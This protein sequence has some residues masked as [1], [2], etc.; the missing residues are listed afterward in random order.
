MT[1]Q[2]YMWT[3]VVVVVAHE[4]APGHT[5][6]LLLVVLLYMSRYLS[7]SRSDGNIDTTAHNN[8]QQSSKQTCHYCCNMQQ[9]PR[10]QPVFDYYT[11]LQAILARLLRALLAALV[12]M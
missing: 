1:D 4:N 10:L 7:R 9:L 3:A 11:S 12:I 6:E 8:K 2:I 5:L